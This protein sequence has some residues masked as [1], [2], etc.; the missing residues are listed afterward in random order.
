MLA[1]GTIAV[2]LTL[3]AALVLQGMTA[4]PA[5]PDL[6]GWMVALISVAIGL[7]L[8]ALVAAFAVVIATIADAISP[9]APSPNLG[10][11][12]LIA[13]IL[14]APFVIWGTV[15]KY[16]TV[17]YQK[18]GHITDRIS[19]AVEQ[20]GAEK[21]VKAD[22]Q[23]RSAR[24]IEVRIGGLLSLERIS[25][26]SVKYDNGRDHVR[27]MEIICAYVRNNAPASSAQQS[28][29][30]IWDKA[31]Q[32]ALEWA[33]EAA[34]RDPRD[35]SENEIAFQAS[36]RAAETCGI[37]P[38]DLDEIMESWAKSLPKPRE[39]IQFALSI[40]GRRDI[41]QRSIEA[42]TGTDDEANAEWV[43]SAPCPLL[44]DP[45]DARSEA[46][47]LLRWRHKFS[48]WEGKISKYRGYRL[49][50]RGT[51]LQKCDMTQADLSRACLD[52]SYL[53]GASLRHGT[54]TAASLIGAHLQKAD[55]DSARL[56][57]ATLDQADLR[58]SSLN[59]ANFAG[60]SFRGTDLSETDIAEAAFWGAKLIQTKMVFAKAHLTR[61][62]GA[63]LYGANLR[64]MSAAGLKLFG[65]RLFGQS[66]EGLTGL[67]QEQLNGTFASPSV[68]LS[69]GLTR[70]QHWQ[71]SSGDWGQFNADVDF[72][73]EYERWLSNPETYTPPPTP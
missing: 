66:L 60:S 36:N 16:Q 15:L 11:G 62:Q 50:L 2:L 48:E 21:V 8:P 33:E 23:E 37:V 53:D 26:D 38:L 64:C 44:S 22:G 58:K 1:F 25:Q 31:Y 71:D 4:R 49:D 43:F 19:K 30:D 20:L 5:A 57:A 3:I 67:T 17:R 47:D 45:T 73:D 14:G 29:E 35:W 9:G 72:D 10:A 65:V 68:T 55:L 59:G 39:D 6:P 12:A 13:A 69:A 32:E 56:P 18:E 27:V 24:N 41:E 61:L 40:L 42:R 28:P 7:F 70:P 34:A 46:Q 51:N 63:T 54:F 52:G